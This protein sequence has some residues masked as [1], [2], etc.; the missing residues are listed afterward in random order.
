MVEDR[1]DMLR[2]CAEWGLCRA[3][4]LALRFALLDQRVDVRKFLSGDCHLGVM[5]AEQ[6]PAGESLPSLL[7]ESDPY[8]HQRPNRRGGAI[9]VPNRKPF[10]IKPKEGAK[11]RN[12]IR[13]MVLLEMVVPYLLT[14]I[15][16]APRALP[17][18]S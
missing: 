3:P 9:K 17:Y 1:G 8:R 12:L 6:I 13:E 2:D 16:R 11:R 18:A 4:S 14:T 5:M 10:V 15:V 7:S